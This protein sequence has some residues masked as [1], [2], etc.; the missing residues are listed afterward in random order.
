[1]RVF[2]NVVN[3]SGIEQ[4]RP[5]LDAVDFVSLRQQEFSQI[6]AVLSGNAGDKGNLQCNLR[7]LNV[8]TILPTAKT[9]TPTAP[10]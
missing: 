4:R 3:A 1:M 10:S 2:V 5:P 9:A 8:S 7:S 6:R